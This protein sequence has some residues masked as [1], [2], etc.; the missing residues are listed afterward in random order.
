MNET[1]IILDAVK[2]IKEDLKEDIIEIKRGM[3]KHS[4]TLYGNGR[5]GLTTVVEII[6]NDIKYIK[7]RAVETKKFRRTIM[8][9]TIATAVTIGLGTFFGV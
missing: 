6:E 1:Q 8:L 4:H 9:S 5:A 7:A 3:N 2:A